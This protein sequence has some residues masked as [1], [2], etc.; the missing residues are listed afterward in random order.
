MQAEKILIET[1]QYGRMLK[2]PKLPPNARMEAIFLLLEDSRKRGKATRK[3][4]A[5]IGG[6][7]KIIG[8]IMAPVTLLEDWE[9][10]R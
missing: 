8:D 10:L 4:S 1:D 5:K 9:A 6:K 7:G 3:P 2:Q